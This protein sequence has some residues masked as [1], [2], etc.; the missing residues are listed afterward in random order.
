MSN[1]AFFCISY[2]ARQ[3]IKQYIIRYFLCQQMIILHEEATTLK[4]HNMEQ[5]CFILSAPAEMNLK[6]FNYSIHIITPKNIMLF[7]VMIREVKF[8]YSLK[9]CRLSISYRYRQALCS[10]E[11][12]LSLLSPFRLFSPLLR[13]RFLCK[14][15]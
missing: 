8:I 9:A 15:T 14:Q 2:S 10:A 7:G 6:L 4:Y 5:L 13:K 3:T 12:R 1:L 11:I